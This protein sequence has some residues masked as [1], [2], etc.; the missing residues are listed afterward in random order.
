M[1]QDIVI[2]RAYDGMSLEQSFGLL[3]LHIGLTRL[4]FSMAGMSELTLDSVLSTEARAFVE[5][6][7]FYI[8]LF[9]Y[10]I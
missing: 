4:C 6:V 10:L 2:L 8:L 3:S 7:F 5:M 9:L 1:S